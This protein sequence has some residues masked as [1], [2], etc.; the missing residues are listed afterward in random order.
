[1]ITV[2]PTQSSRFIR[3]IGLSIQA[4]I[5]YII[6]LLICLGHTLRAQVIYVDAVKGDDQATGSVSQPVSSLH[7]AV[8]LSRT[9][10]GERDITIKLAPGLYVLS[11]LVK[12]QPSERADTTR[13]TL[14]AFIMPD[15]T[16]WKPASMPVIQSISANNLKTYFEH[17]AGL[18]ILRN[19]VSIRGV[20]F[21]G[22]ANPSV[23][24]Y[25][26]IERDSASLKDL[27]VSQ[28]LFIGERN[29]APIQGAIYMEGT[30]TVQVDHCVFYHCKNALLLFYSAKGFSLTHSIIDGSY[31][32]AIWY[33][34]KKEADAS[35]VF[36]NNIVTGSDYF[37]LSSRSED[38]PSF[39]FSNSVITGN[40]H[41]MGIYDS[42]AGLTPYK[43]PGTHKERGIQKTGKVI[44]NQVSPMDIPRNY[45]Q[46]TAQSTGYNQVP[47]YSGQEK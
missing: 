27:R 6:L 29:W 34:Y 45:L 38:H 47:G 43:R 14:E 41:Y 4:V 1:M 37:F 20:K 36:Q 33:G 26:P 17:C 8:Q 35:F 3:S 25:Y 46:P 44:L 16:A 23:D 19:K 40:H 10:S 13:F 7:Q 30:N 18:E 31:E 22:N 42:G 12:I 28:C 21:V 11:Q 2:H 5:G 15:D 24:Y 39:T 32:S 9:F